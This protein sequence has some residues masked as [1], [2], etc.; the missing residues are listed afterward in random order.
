MK[1]IVIEDSRLAR[2]GLVRMLERHADICVVDTADNIATALTA[3][4]IH[5]PDLLFL[6]IHLPEGSGF[7]LLAKIDYEP[8][9]IFT[10]AFSEYAIQSFNYQTVDYLL[11]PI[12]RARLEDAI[13]KLYKTVSHRADN[14]ERLGVTDKIMLK[15][16]DRCA[17]VD[18]AQI[19]YVEIC[20]NYVQIFFNEEKYFVKRTLSYIEDKLPDNIFFRASRQCVINR[21]FVT[22][23]E[24]GVGDGYEVT[25]ANGMAVELSRR[26]T[27]QLKDMLKF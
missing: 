4:N 22:G 23:L 18:V 17:I 13:N 9:I 3:I 26:G 2:E 11:K 14:R 8:R 6:D 1:A 12:S 20:K 10:T 15:D 5:K 27:I 7:D 21:N 16:G 25:L 19:Q 24:E